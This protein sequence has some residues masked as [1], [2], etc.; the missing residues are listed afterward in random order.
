MSEHRSEVEQRLKAMGLTLPVPPAPVGS[1]V[2]VVRVKDLIF[3][4]GILPVIDGKL[5]QTGRLGEEVDV[6]KGREAAKRA[7]LNALAVIKRELG[8]LDHVARVV[9]MTGYV[10]SGP[11]FYDQPAVLNG[12]SDFLVELFQDAGRHARVAV[13][14]AQLPL[15]SPI[16]IE[17]IIQ[18]HD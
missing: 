9:K 13:G 11:E 7:A 1:Y 5:D 6:E 18:V 4:S 8:S 10:A 14:T 2:P 17:L 15:N 16:E 12:A 3:T